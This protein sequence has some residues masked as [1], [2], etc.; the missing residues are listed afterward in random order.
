MREAVGGTWL[1]QLVIVIMF[2]FVAFLALSMNYSKAFRVKNEILSIIEKKEG[3]LQNNNANGSIFLINN[4]LKNSGY[5]TVGRCEKGSYGFNINSVHATL[6]NDGNKNNK[7]NYCISKTKSAAI[8]FPNRAYYKVKI[9]FKFNLP[10]VGDVYTF[11]VDGE[12]KDV[13]YPKDGKCGTNDSIKCV[14]SDIDT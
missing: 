6:I 14:R 2:V 5:N 10:V 8:N 4:Y 9:F 13:N 12:T 11:K 3:I 7:F 1:T